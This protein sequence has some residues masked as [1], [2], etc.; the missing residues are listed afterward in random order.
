MRSHV[1]HN[2]CERV[3]VL[4]GQQYR[5][6]KNVANKPEPKNV[7]WYNYPIRKQIDKNYVLLY[8]TTSKNAY[9]YQF[10]QNDIETLWF[11]TDF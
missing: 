5:T 4:R 6:A 11:L 3:F 9:M 2:T 1:L 10:C 8:K 7:K